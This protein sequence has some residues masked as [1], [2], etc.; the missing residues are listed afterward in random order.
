[1]Y[2]DNNY[3]DIIHESIFSDDMSFLP[4]SKQVDKLVQSLTSER[5]K[6]H[7]KQSIWLWSHDFHH[8]FPSSGRSRLWSS[9][10]SWR[11]H[12]LWQSSQSWWMKYRTYLRLLR[13]QDSCQLG[14]FVRNGYWQIQPTHSTYD[15]KIFTF[16]I[17]CITTVAYHIYCWMNTF[18][19]FIDSGRWE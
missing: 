6:V 11:L 16:R 10:G 3:A 9:V 17:L 15:C 19:I 12:T 14:T 5:S 7:L 18:I 4:Q 1:M 8:I 2:C 13:R